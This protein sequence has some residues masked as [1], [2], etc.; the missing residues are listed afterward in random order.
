M[1]EDARIMDS[2]DYHDWSYFVSVAVN[3][4]KW[5]DMVE[6]LMHPAGMRVLPN[7]RMDVINNSVATSTTVIT[8]ST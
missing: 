3:P 1:N 6:N 7:F 2:I 8:S 4:S 5:V